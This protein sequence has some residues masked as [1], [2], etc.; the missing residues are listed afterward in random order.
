MPCNTVFTWS[1][2]VAGY[3]KL[4]L[5]FTKNIPPAQGIE[6]KR[7]YLGYEQQPSRGPKTP[8]FLLLQSPFLQSLSLLSLTSFH[9]ER[10]DRI[11]L[12]LP[13]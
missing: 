1:L 9:N 2:Q 13:T 7:A 12:Y 8:L 10:T 5:I 3:A 6:K 11:Q 4:L